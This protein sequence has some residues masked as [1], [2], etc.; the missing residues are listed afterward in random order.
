MS[1]STIAKPIF[2]TADSTS[3]TMDGLLPYINYRVSRILAL[4]AK[5][6]QAKVEKR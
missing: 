1:F 2:S 6:H 3:G 5:I 4:R